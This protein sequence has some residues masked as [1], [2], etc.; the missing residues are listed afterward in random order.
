MEALRGSYGNNDCVIHIG[1]P[2]N[3][4]YCA[5]MVSAAVYIAN[6]E[7]ILSY[8]YEKDS[9]DQDGCTDECDLLER[10]E[11]QKMEKCLSLR[12]QSSFANKTI[13]SVMDW[14]TTTFSSN[15]SDSVLPKE[16]SRGGELV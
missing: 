8:F 9:M 13:E 3:T 16:V 12:K 10:G 5:A 11:M 2:N 14:L 15:L 4:I 7:E 1:I 6:R